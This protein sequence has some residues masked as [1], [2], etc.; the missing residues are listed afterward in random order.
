MNTR[1]ED[2]VTWLMPVKNGMPFLP[3][4]LASIESQ[5]YRN[6]EM[7]VWDNGSTDG[8]VEELNR[9]IPSR[10][11]GRVITGEP[12]SLGASRAALVE[13]AATELCA[14]I[15]ADDINFSTRL[16]QQVAFMQA[17]PEIAIVGGQMRVINDEGADLGPYWPRVLL[18]DDIV[19]NLLHTSGL[20]QGTVMFRRS[21]VLAAGNYR[22]QV[23]GCAEDYDL[24][25]RLLVKYRAAALDAQMI[26]Y[27]RHV[28]S[29]SHIAEQES[30]LEDETVVQFYKTA[31]LLYGCSKTEAKLLR[32]RRHPLTAYSLF[33]IALYLHRTQK[34]G[35]SM[36][37]RLR[38]DSFLHA[39]KS[40]T[41]P[42]DVASR[43]ALAALNRKKSAL[44]KEVLEMVK[45]VLKLL[46][47]RSFVLRLKRSQHA[48]RSGDFPHGANNA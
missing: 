42:W 47:I 19:H 12:L 41:A 6:W 26:W 28:S 40:L 38:S 32:E 22:S 18:H 16:E 37:Q 2:R 27:R 8:T 13:H 24:W 20:A 30:R 45:D 33:R 39:G 44:L 7:L 46:G 10:L 3:E 1:T 17:H 9:W 31:P 34:S 15:D 29:I 36:V 11:P 25:L 4:T 14:C 35:G 5:T 48:V 43:F 23:P 21:A